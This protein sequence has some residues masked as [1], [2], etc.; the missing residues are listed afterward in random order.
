MRR[1]ILPALLI[2]ALY[3][4]SLGQPPPLG[5]NAPNLN[6]ISI[7]E[8]YGLFQVDPS[9]D[10]ADA[11]AGGTVSLKIT[12]TTVAGS[13]NTKDGKTEN[14][15]VD[16]CVPEGSAAQL[17]IEENGL[18]KED[19][20]GFLVTNFFYTVE[21]DQNAEPR[22]HRIRLGLQYLNNEI[23]YRSFIFKVG[24]RSKGKLSVVQDEE[25][26]EPTFYTGESNSNQLTL[27]ND[28][29]DYTVN[30]KKISVKSIP[31]DLVEYTDNALADAPISLKPSEQKTVQLNFKVKGMD[32]SK[33]ISGLG[34][35]PKL[36][37]TVT[38]DDGN[39]R[40]I[41]DFTHKLAAK[42]RPRDRVLWMAMLA[43]VILGAAL[44]Y[45]LQP[46]KLSKDCRWRPLVKFFCY[47]VVF[48]IFVAA[49]AMLGKV[50][51]GAIKNVGSYDKPLAIFIVGA[52]ATI[53]SLQVIVSLF[54]AVTPAKQ[55]PGAAQEK[56]ARP[57]LRRRKRRETTQ[58]E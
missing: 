19:K 57:K 9:Y 13:P 31:D 5:D 33:L 17:K 58:A 32:F 34:E 44:R 18:D 22:H 23:L 56:R 16:S 3:S 37:L 40:E 4:C 53:G 46:P 7:K 2:F 41:S 6:R 30:I 29:P 21:I 11:Y 15:R 24:V 43:G 27:R 35:K 54:Q 38:Y 12:V 39:K 25:P 14:L 36:L 52:L 8:S 45:Y 51:V 50:E 1:I 28:F 49:L 26:N 48:G 55:T 20:P 42:F 10:S 47:T